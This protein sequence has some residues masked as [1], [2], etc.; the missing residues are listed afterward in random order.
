MRPRNGFTLIELLVVIAIIAILAAILFP[1]FARARESARKTSCLSNTKQ[2]MLAMKQYLA[3][4]DGKTPPNRQPIYR[5]DAR[6]AV[7]GARWGCYDPAWYGGA[8]AVFHWYDMLRPYAKSTGILLCPSHD[9]RGY[10]IGTGSLRDAYNPSNDISGA[11]NIAGNPI[12]HPD[13]GLNE[14]R[15]ERPASIIE[16]FETNW[17]CPDLGWWSTQGMDLWVHNGTM[18]VGYA[19]G[20]AKAIKIWST[21]RFKDTGNLADD[22]WWS[23][24]VDWGWNDAQWLRDREI[25]SINN[26]RSGN[27]E[28]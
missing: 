26:I 27:P 21:L 15:I 10:G 18:N 6:T 4:Y 23:P 25:E 3:D 19:D 7:W 28:K 22:H 20:H 1:V 9:D 24:Y 5:S 11:A 2:V 17:D 16:S 12:L 14:A 13:N 8:P